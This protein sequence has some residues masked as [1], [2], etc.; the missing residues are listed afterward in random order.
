M[1]LLINHNSKLHKFGEGRVETLIPRYQ[2]YPDLDMVDYCVVEVTLIESAFTDI[3]LPYEQESTLVG[4]CYP[5]HVD[6]L[7]YIEEF[8]EK[9]IEEFATLMN[10]CSPNHQQ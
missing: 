3:V 2:D 1:V 6:H 7:V 10:S 5:W 8:K 4:E 9:T